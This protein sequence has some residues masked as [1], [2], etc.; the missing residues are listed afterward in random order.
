ML[1]LV[2]ALAAAPAMAQNEMKDALD[3]ADA[4]AR[5]V[6]EQLVADPLDPRVD[7]LHVFNR[8]ESM[9]EPPDS[10]LEGCTQVTAGEGALEE[11]CLQRTKVYVRFIVE[12]DGSLT[13]PALVKGACPT[14]DRLAL[15]CVHRSA[16]WKPG[17]Q[18]GAPVR[19][20]VVVPV[21]FEPR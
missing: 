14:L 10:F 19:V 17:T 6:M 12:R 1:A 4:R 2:C 3:T 15:E 11:A 20:Q 5:A 8:V 7:T 13:S 9:P 18:D 16:R 21:Q